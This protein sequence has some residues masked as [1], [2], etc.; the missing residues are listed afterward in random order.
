MSLK[1]TV[2]NIEKAMRALGLRVQKGAV[3]KFI[4]IY[5]STPE[6]AR[7]AFSGGDVYGYIAGGG[8][9]SPVLKP[10][11]PGHGPSIDFTR[12]GLTYGAQKPTALQARSAVFDDLDELLHDKGLD[13][14]DVVKSKRRKSEKR[15]TTKAGRGVLRRHM[16]RDAR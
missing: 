14:E 2:G 5:R 3:A 15:K 12:R 10:G 16:K 9:G 6:G 1:P 4:T 7:I 8:R 11:L 13:I